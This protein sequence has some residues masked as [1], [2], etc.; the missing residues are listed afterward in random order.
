MDAMTRLVDRE[1]RRQDILRRVEK[2]RRQAEREY[3][4]KRLNRVVGR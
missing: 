2:Q 3:M 4:Q 1:F